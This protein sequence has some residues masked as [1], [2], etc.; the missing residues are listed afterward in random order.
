MSA[1]GQNRKSSV[2]H[3]MSALGGEADVIKAK[4]DMESN[5]EKADLFAWSAGRV[6]VLN[7][8]IDEN[9]ENCSQTVF[10]CL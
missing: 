7:S 8:N 4:A 9:N 1:W 3:G 5:G 6:S 2:G 10:D